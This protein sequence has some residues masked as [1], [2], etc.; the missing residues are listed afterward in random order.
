[1][2]RPRVMPCLLLRNKGLVKTIKFKNARYIGDPMNAVR[3]FNAKEA[4]ELIFLDID[5]SK[6]QRKLPLDLITK[7]GDEAFMPF[8][9]GGGISS[10][11]DI[12]K[13]LN[14]GAEKVSINTSAVEDPQFIRQASSTF[15]TSTIVVSIDVKKKLF[16]RSQVFIRGGTRAAGIDPITHAQ[17]MEEMGAGELLVTSIDHDGT[18]EGYD[19]ELIKSISDTVTIPVVA[20]GGAGGPEDFTSAV[21]QGNASAVAAGSCFVY[22][23]PRRAVLINFPSADELSDLFQ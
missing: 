11:D 16:G 9:V 21:Q 7:I 19:L 4:D 22:H 13:I 20:C 3:I 18:M 2:F 1:M 12:R 5:A 15:G 14:A 10:I 17:R 23:G 6:E 8:T